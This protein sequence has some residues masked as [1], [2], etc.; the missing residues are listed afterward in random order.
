VTDERDRADI[1]ESAHAREVSSIDTVL[2]SLRDSIEETAS[3]LGFDLPDNEDGLGRQIWQLCQ[4]SR[5]HISLMYQKSLQESAR[6]L[7]F[8][9]RPNPDHDLYRPEHDHAVVAFLDGFVED[10]ITVC[11][12]PNSDDSR[13]VVDRL[14]AV[15]DAQEKI[16]AEQAR[17]IESLEKRLKSSMKM[18]VEYEVLLK[19]IMATAGS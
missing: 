17:R 3:H 9:L 6:L 12:R 7:S 4:W 10:V 15:I 5:I 2:Q 13:M 18:L 8:G 16:V 14:I 11:K 1:A 19:Q